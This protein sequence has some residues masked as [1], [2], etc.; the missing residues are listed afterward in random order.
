MT[1]ATGTVKFFDDKRGYGFLRPD[2]GGADVFVHRSHLDESCRSDQGLTLAQ[3]W[4]V[5]FDIIESTKGQKAAS[6]R[7]IEHP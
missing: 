2:E 6:V 5:G 3:G 1:R 4:R 7:L